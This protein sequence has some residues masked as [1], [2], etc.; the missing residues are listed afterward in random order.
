MDNFFLD[1]TSWFIAYGII[2]SIT[3]GILLLFDKINFWIKIIL[4]PMVLLLGVQAYTTY[5]E[6]LGYPY[7]GKFDKDTYFIL[8]KINKKENY[9]II[10]GYSAD[11]KRYRVYHR[12]Y[13]ENLEKQMSE[14]AKRSKRGE[15]VQLRDK[16]NT[17]DIE[18]KSHFP[19]KF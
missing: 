17:N 13:E 4:I 6:I 9:I 12:P 3:I 11:N 5:S 14:A 8:S 1:I 18:V 2:T 7:S 10:V 19:P 15:K 16:D